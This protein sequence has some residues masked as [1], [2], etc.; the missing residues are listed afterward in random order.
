MVRLSSDE[1]A[2]IAAFLG[3][4]DSGFRS[5]YLSAA[6]DRLK[7]G[8]GL[9]CVFLEDGRE[10]GCSIYPVRPEKC[11]TWPYWPELRGGGEALAEA[12]RLCPGIDLLDVPGA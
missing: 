4:S 9:R 6:G 2:A 12:R 10:A 11:G 3:L 7:E 1:S 8:L 5:R